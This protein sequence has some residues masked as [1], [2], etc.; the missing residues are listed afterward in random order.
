[1]ILGGTFARAYPLLREIVE[2][3]LNRRVLLPLRTVELALGGLLA[4]PTTV[5][6]KEEVA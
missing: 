1:V 5:P 6:L 4:D 2:D 3:E